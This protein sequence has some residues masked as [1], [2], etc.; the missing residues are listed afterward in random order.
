MAVQRSVQGDTIEMII[1][2][3][4]GRQSAT[5]L[6]AVLMADGNEQLPGHGLFLPVGTL[7]H[8]PTVAEAQEVKELT[9]IQELWH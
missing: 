7:V 9:R 1:F 8:L 6:D 2:N 4:Y 3:H 5:L